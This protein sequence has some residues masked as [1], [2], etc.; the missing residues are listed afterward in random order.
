MVSGMPWA[1]IECRFRLD[2]CRKCFSQIV[3]TSDNFL[4]LLL[5]FFAS[6]VNIF[7]EHLYNVEIWETCFNTYRM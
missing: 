2:L 4:H 3:I 1:L 7:L 5:L 6:L